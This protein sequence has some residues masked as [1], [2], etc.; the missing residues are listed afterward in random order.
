MLTQITWERELCTNF[1]T[2]AKGV[3]ISWNFLQGWDHW[4]TMLKKILPVPSL[5]QCYQETF[6]TFPTYLASTACP[7]MSLCSMWNRYIQPSNAH[8][9]PPKRLNPQGP[10]FPHSSLLAYHSQ[11]VDSA[12]TCVPS[13]WF[14]LQVSSRQ[15]YICNCWSGAHIQL[16]WWPARPTSMPKSTRAHLTGHHTQ[17]TQETPWISCL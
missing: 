15:K 14:P 2:C 5:A 17:P 11:W 1:R 10:G 7:A 16:H 3:R 12:V 9:A 4:L 6:L 8:N 13:R